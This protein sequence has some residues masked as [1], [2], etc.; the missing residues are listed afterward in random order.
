VGCNRRFTLSDSILPSFENAGGSWQSGSVCLP[1]TSVPV[2]GIRV[3]SAEG[4]TWLPSVPA[5][6]ASDLNPLE[7][8]RRD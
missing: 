3:F 5:R 1:L 7:A 2:D 6:R 8:F 4:E